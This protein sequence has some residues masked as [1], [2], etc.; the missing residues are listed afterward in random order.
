MNDILSV[1]SLS[2]GYGSKNVLK[3]LDFRI[4]S[5]SVAAIIG[6]NG[7]GKTTLLK[8]IMGA[9]PLS[10]GSMFYQGEPHRPRNPAD[11]VKNGIR[12]VPEGTPVFADMTVAENLAV[13]AAAAAP[14]KYIADIAYELF[15]VLKQRANQA[16]GTLSGGERK[17]LGVGMALATQPKLLL[18]DEPSLGL[19]PALVQTVFEKVA[20]VREQSE[21]SIIVIEQNVKE[22]LKIADSIHI[23]K[24]GNV[25]T[26]M[27]ARSVK[28]PVELFKWF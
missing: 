14:T 7:A 16:A 12:L 5:R 8:T 19:A 25:I 15:P 18:L 10:G 22:V 9:V 26:S 21:L 20:A 13:A 6:H 24:L 3:G 1:S 28:S 23:M 2:S 17:M 4:A 11:A 27:E